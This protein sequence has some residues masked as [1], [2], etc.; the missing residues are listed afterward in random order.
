MWIDI[1]ALTNKI[2]HIIGIISGVISIIAAFSIEGMYIG[3]T[4]DKYTYG[5]EAYTGIQNAAAQAGWN[6]YDLTYI[7]REGLFAILLVLGIALIC[8]FTAQLT[9]EDMVVVKTVNTVNTG[10]NPP[11]IQSD[12]SYPP[13]MDEYN[14]NR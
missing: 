12:T 13:N 3:G 8:F 10:S 11:R 7:V 9:R 5:G 4:V 6:I 2:A 1:K 14:Y